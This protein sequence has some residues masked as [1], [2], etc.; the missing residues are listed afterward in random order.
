MDGGFH[1]RSS[2]ATARRLLESIDV[3]DISG[4]RDRALLAAMMYSRQRPIGTGSVRRA[5]LDLI[6]LPPT[7]SQVDAFVDDRLPDAWERLIDSLLTS[8]H[9]GERYGRVWLD[10][11]RYADSAGFE[12]DM[13]RPNAWRYRDYVIKSFNGD[14]PHDRFLVPSRVKDCCAFHARPRA[15]SPRMGYASRPAS[16]SSFACSRRPIQSAP[17]R[18]RL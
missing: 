17:M 8:P 6:G 7:P 15:R 14:K 9:G 18:S 2:T 12:Y 10:V 11:V 3:T 1:W 4:P 5:Y 16:G 13:H